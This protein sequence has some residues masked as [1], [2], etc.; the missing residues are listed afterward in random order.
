LA[1]SFA[2]NR[3]WTFSSNQ[4]VTHVLP[5]YLLVTAISYFLN[6]GSVLLATSYFSINP[7]L[8]Q[9]LGIAPYTSCMFLGCS[10]FVFVMAPSARILPG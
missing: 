4:P 9:L 8:A 1:V 5:K 7:Y 2:L 6:L 3:V 10:W